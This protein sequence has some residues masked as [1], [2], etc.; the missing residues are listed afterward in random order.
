MDPRRVVGVLVMSAW[1][2]G[3]SR[4]E[5]GRPASVAR[6]SLHAQL[7]RDA[8]ERLALPLSP[9]GSGEVVLERAEATRAALSPPP[10]VTPSA[11]EPNA[12]ALPVAEPAPPPE[13]SVAAPHMTSDDPQLKPPI[14]RGLP[15]LPRG[16][17]GG[18]VAL[19]VRVDE[20]GEVSD[21]ELVETDADS[22]TVAAAI[23]AAYTLRFYPALLGDRSVAV[24][25]RQVFQ[26]RRAR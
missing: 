12:P 22:A 24:W 23:E 15:L 6:D 20:H 14:P 16:G 7:Q 26:V 10:A 19:D 17:R 1:L 21:A 3:C 4:P 13:G 2:A 18:R 25:T 11:P 8:P 5:R 9:R